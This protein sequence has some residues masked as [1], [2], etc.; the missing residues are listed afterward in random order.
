MGR[1]R[2][3]RPV[4]V[5]R[6]VCGT[7][8]RLKSLRSPRGAQ[9]GTTKKSGSFAS[10][11]SPAERALPCIH[12]LC[13]QTRPDRCSNAK[14]DC[15]LQSAS[16]SRGS[17]RM[18]YLPFFALGFR[19]N[20]FRRLTDDELVAVAVLRDELLRLARNSSDH[21]QVLGAQGRG[22]STCLRALAARFT[23]DG[24]RTVYEY[25]TP[26][27]NSFRT[28]LDRLDVFLL[29]EA[30]RL[31]VHERTRL[32]AAASNRRRGLRLVVGVHDDMSSPFFSHRLPL[33]T[34][35]IDSITPAYLQAVLSRRLALFAL[36]DPP[37]ITF[38]ADAV[39][40]LCDAFGSDLR[41]AERFLYEVFQSKPPHG[42]LTSAM[43]AWL[44]NRRPSPAGEFQ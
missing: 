23:D 26:G 8:A 44:E 35:H 14:V 41:L 37:A 24:L 42:R 7:T 3:P 19:S 34:V 15:R 20:P 28:S 11:D 33:A 21:I 13:R 10:P 39:R 22:K 38:S 32:L 29:D 4:L 16:Q 31:E 27:R 1:C 25:L 6:P 18:D 2:S 43:L 9:H 5:R 36:D 12:G 30:Q 40:Y 17:Y